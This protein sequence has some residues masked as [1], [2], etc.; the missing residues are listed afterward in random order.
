MKPKKKTKH[1]PKWLY[2]F[3]FLPAMHKFSSYSTPLPTLGQLIY[4]FFHSNR[5]VVIY[6]VILIC[7]SLM[8]NNVLH[9]KVL[10]V[11]YMSSF[12][13]SLFKPFLCFWWVVFSILNCNFLLWTLNRS[14][15]R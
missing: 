3:V 8:I 1:Y 12:I 9:F 11:I 2:H 15:L 10:L 5:F 7:I 13:T 6:C 4:L 14:L